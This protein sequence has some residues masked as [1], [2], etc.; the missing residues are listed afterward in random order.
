VDE[1]ATCARD[2]D[3]QRQLAAALD[4]RRLEPA[5]QLLEGCRADL[6]AALAGGAGHAAERRQSPVA[7]GP[8]A[9]FLEAVGATFGGFRRWQQPIGAVGLVALGFF[10]ARLT[11]GNPAALAPQPAAPS[12]DVYATIRSV[13]PEQAGVVRIA[14]DET[15]RRELTGRAEDPNIQRLLLAGT[16]GENA[17]VRVQSVDVLSEQPEPGEVLDAL[18][19]ALSHDP[20]PGVR[21][22]ALDGLKTLSGNPQVRRAVAGSL[23]SDDDSAV[24][25]K[26]V[27]LLITQ[28][29]PAMVGFL[30]G[31]VQRESNDYVRTRAE[32]A[33]R[34]WNASVG[35]F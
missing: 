30:Q 20:N 31:M 5:T 7:K 14:F 1:C 33:L 22:K 34:D 26:A 11:G 28:H 35:T 4:R 3:R 2:L 8:W 32:K 18:L 17:A 24:R 10:A 27:D 19:N 16:R 23:V 6:M 9:L 21:L 25:S 13:Q 12:D 15:R 29:D